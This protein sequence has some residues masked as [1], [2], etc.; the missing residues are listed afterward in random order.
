MAKINFKFKLKKTHIIIAASIILAAA[1]FL[2]YF[3]TRSSSSQIVW[4]GFM[5]VWL[6]L[7]L[8]WLTYRRLPQVSYLFIATSL[9]I[10]LLV[11]VDIYWIASK[12]L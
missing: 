3:L 5:L 11:V 4:I 2:I 1:N 9:L 6:N 12:Y 10:E 8:S 7:I